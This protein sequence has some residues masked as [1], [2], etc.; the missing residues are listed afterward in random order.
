MSSEAERRALDRLDNERLYNAVECALAM[1]AKPPEAEAILGRVRECFP[2]PV[3]FLEADDSV[4]QKLPLT[5][6][7]AYYFS[8]APVIARFIV[9]ERFGARPK[10]DRLERMAGYMVQLYRG[11]YHERFYAVLLD[12]AGRVTDTVLISRGSASA[13]LFDLKTLLS[14][15]IQHNAKAVALCHNHPRGTPRPSEEDVRCTL[16][17]LKAL[18]ALDVPM[19]DHIIVA[20]DQAVSLRETGAVSPDLWVMQA[21]KNRVVRDWL[22]GVQAGG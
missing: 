20:Y 9:R 2:A 3:F 16:D 5:E 12:S 15:V 10:L 13:T 19:L 18:R 4:K 6:N 22:K 11:V 17:A 21:P 7:T 1:L 14:A 8:L